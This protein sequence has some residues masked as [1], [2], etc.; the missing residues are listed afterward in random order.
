MKGRPRK[1]FKRY[2]EDCGRLYQPSGKF[3]RYCDPCQKVRVHPIRAGSN[4][5]LSNRLERFYKEK[6]KG[7]NSRGDTI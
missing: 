3:Q 5:R 6:M 4:K 2:C 1:S 7:L